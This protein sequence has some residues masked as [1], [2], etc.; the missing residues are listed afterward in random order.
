MSNFKVFK[1]TLQAHI[2]EFLKNNPTLYL[3]SAKK[4]TMWDI[5]QESFPD[6]YNEVFRERREYDCSSCRTF[7]TEFARVV[8]IDHN[9]VVSIWQDLDVMYPFNIVTEHL[10]NYVTSCDIEDRFITPYSKFGTNSNVE[11]LEDNTTITW[12]HFYY[13]LPQQFVYRGSQ[14]MDTVKANYRANKETLQRSITQI[15][16]SAL[17]TVLELI[18]D[19]NLYKGEEWQK[20]LVEFQTLRNKYFK[21]HSKYQDAFLWANSENTVI[22]K[23]KNHSIGTLLINLSEGMDLQVAINKYEAI[24][25]PS[26]Y[27]RSKSVFTESQK[28]KAEQFVVE[29]GYMDSLY[30][31]FATLEDIIINNLLWANRKTAS[32]L[33]N[34]PFDDIKSTKGDTTPNKDK[35]Q[36]VSI[37]DFVA[38]VLPSTKNIKVF[39]ENTHNNNFVS[40][41]APQIIDSKPLFKWGNNFSWVYTNNL[42]DSDIK[43]NVEKFGGKTDGVMRFSIQWNTSNN[44]NLND[45]DAHCKLPSGNEI[46]F[47]NK[48]DRITKG[49]LDV[50]IIEPIG[51][52]VENITFPSFEYLTSGIYNFFVHTYS[53]RGYKGFQAEFE[54]NGQVWQFD[55]PNPDPYKT[56]VIKVNVDAKNKTVNIIQ[57]VNFTTKS[58][59]NWGISTQQWVD[60]N[61]I[62]YSPN[63]WNGQGVGN[64][65]YMF[66]LEKCINPDTPS[67]FFNEYLTEDLY[68]NHRQVFEALSNKMRVEQSDNQLSGLGFSSTQRNEV[69]VTAENFGLLNIQF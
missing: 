50:D 5:F 29:N 3:S 17:A 9:K 38:E 51:V 57:S 46:Y 1:E 64:R 16:A 66:M 34:S 10:A 6:G 45:E 35:A 39:V 41:I 42:T 47:S 53:N 15:S 19:N 40:L 28:K 36:Q 58:I 26:N 30:R 44:K 11:L 25:A 65:H 18:N 55:I 22:S 63:Y 32:L 52:A 20:V 37:T 69:L 67:G 2:D 12:N 49:S 59:E 43:R 68:R 48:I 62:M 24:V 60:V 31:R 8:K 14:T 61:S 13:Q 33:T 7:F 54:F 4:D 56:T 23:I 27:K 21:L